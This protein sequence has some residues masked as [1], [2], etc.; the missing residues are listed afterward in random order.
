MVTSFALSLRARARDSAGQ[1]APSQSSRRAQVQVSAALSCAG[2]RAAP[3]RVGTRD[4]QTSPRRAGLFGQLSC[5]KK[6]ALPP[7][8]QSF[9]LA[10]ACHQWAQDGHTHWGTDAQFRLIGSGASNSNKRARLL[11]DREFW[12]LGL[13]FP[14]AGEKMAAPGAESVSNRICKR[15]SR[16]GRRMGWQ[17]RGS[18]RTL[19]DVGA[20][21][22]GAG[23]D[24]YLPS[25]QVGFLGQRWP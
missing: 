23:D 3:A 9:E 5:A 14:T 21:R 24:K 4:C 22:S 18:Q 2:S 25:A 11:V 8:G 1:F 16:W 19:I 17:K 20:R 6:R 15:Y 7:W 12:P 10:N 13:E